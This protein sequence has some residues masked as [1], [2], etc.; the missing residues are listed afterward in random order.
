V[1]LCSHCLADLTSN[2]QEGLDIDHSEARPNPR[3]AWPSWHNITTVDGCIREDS[4]IVAFMCVGR[5]GCGCGLGVMQPSL[6]VWALDLVT[7]II[8]VDWGLMGGKE[9]Q[10]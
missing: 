5:Q 2:F 1:D 3:M 4:P 7:L 10:S 6:G 8:N 9:L